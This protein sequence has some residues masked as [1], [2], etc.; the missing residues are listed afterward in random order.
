VIASALDHV[1]YVLRHGRVQ[2]DAELCE[3]RHQGLAEG[4]EI[5]LGLPDVEDL[6]GAV[7]LEGD[8]VGAAL[9]RTGT[10]RLQLLDGSVVLLGRESLVDEA[11]AQCR[12]A[13]SL[14]VVR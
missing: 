5:L 6:D 11:E 8:V 2:C 12:G 3:D 10:G 7:R 13:N 1:V 4:V 9:R 14:S